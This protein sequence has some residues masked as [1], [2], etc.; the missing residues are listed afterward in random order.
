MKTNNGFT[1]VELMV[2]IAIAAIL[3]AI[4]VPSFNNMLADNRLATETNDVIGAIQFTRS[5][6]IR[7]NRTITFCRAAS[8]AA[9][10]CTGGANWTDWIVTNNPAAGTA[11]TTLRRGTFAQSGGTMGIGSTLAASRMAFRPDGLTDAV[12]GANTVRIC[13]T[14]STTNNVRQIEVGLSGRT[15]TATLTGGCP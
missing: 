4:A 7:R 15:T 1:L 10:T 12:G 3:M 6:A 11:D 9:N 2:T 8:A 14:S 13:T 5:E